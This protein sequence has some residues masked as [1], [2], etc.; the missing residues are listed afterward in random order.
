M[1]ALRARMALTSGSKLG[2]CEIQSH[3]QVARRKRPFWLDCLNAKSGEERV[4]YK[5][6]NST[7][8]LIQ[9]TT[10]EAPQ[11]TFMYYIGLD[12]HKKTISYCVK[13]V[14]G[15]VH[16]EGKIGANATRTRRLDEDSPSTMDGSHGGNDFHG[17]DLQ[18]SAAARATGEGSASTDAARHRRGEKEER[19]D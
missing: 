7:G 18:S 19:S 8:T 6:L 11:G 15:Q 13:D 3:L 14:S 4:V 12:V 17:L 10:T 1:P 5:K 16:Q 9:R 2:S